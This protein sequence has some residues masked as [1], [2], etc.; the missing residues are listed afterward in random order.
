MQ[1]PN[2][3]INKAAPE[4]ALLGLAGVLQVSQTHTT[5]KHASLLPFASTEH[6]HINSGAGA[7]RDN[8]VPKFQTRREGDRSA[9]ALN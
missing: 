6:S 4:T 8:R 1:T 2:T 7:E 9:K 5:R 3:S